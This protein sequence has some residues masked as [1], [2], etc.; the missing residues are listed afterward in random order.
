MALYA[1][2]EDAT[3]VVVN[4]VVWDGVT[5]WEPPAGTTVV[6]DVDGVAWIGGTYVDGEFAPQPPSEVIFT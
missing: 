2:V 4:I 5:P 3:G 6:E 1:I